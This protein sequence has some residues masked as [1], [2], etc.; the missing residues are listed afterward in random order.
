MV[1]LWLGGKHSY[2][3]TDVGIFF[4]ASTRSGD[5]TYTPNGGIG[6]TDWHTYGNV[7]PH[8]L[9]GG[10]WNDSANQ[11]AAGI[12]PGSGSFSGLFKSFP[13]PTSPTSPTCG[14]S[15]TIGSK[16]C[17][18]SYAFNEWNAP[19]VCGAAYSYSR[20]AGLFHGVRNGRLDGNF[21]LGSFHYH[22]DCIVLPDWASSDQDGYLCIGWLWNMFRNCGINSIALFV[23]TM[24]T[25]S[26][27]SLH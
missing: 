2:S 23:K 26:I 20:A 13:Q 1:S 7:Y 5:Y 4:A 11:D 24:A 9:F 21:D 10:H 25:S 6:S 16:N 19:A 8:V 3:A 12:W 17:S 27:C 18:D 22:S 14:S 15:Y